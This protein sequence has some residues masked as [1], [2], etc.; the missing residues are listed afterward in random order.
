VT[1]VT[2][3]ITSQGDTSLLQ[4]APYYNVSYD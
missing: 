4:S 2:V 3:D 1:E